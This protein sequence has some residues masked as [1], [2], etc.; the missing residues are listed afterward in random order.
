ME[1]DALNT[2]Q[3]A[4]VEAPAVAPQ[5]A[6]ATVAEQQAEALAAQQQAAAVAAQQQ[7]AQ[8]PE[9]PAK[10]SHGG[11]SLAELRRERAMAATKEAGQ[12]LPGP[13]KPIGV[14]VRPREIMVDGQLQVM[15]DEKQDKD[16][17]GRLQPEAP[18]AAPAK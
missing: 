8:T 18:A 12:V 2:E 9:A 4:A 1:L 7:A 6:E 3:A 13:R 14:E 17:G 11:K 10:P 16:F 5:Q 15:P